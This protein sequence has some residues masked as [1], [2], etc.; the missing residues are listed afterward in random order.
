M[1]INYDNAAGKEE[2]VSTRDWLLP[3]LQYAGLLS[4]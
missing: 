1:V 2:N 4:W 3:G